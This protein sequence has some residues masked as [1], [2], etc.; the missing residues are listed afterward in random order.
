MGCGRRWGIL[1][2]CR[3]VLRI[4]D[5]EAQA[6]GGRLS[7][8]SVGTVLMV[9]TYPGVGYEVEFTNGDITT[10]TWLTLYD[11]DLEALDETAADR[12]C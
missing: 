2:G 10:L 4:A 11:D 7:G 1:R 9:Y 8:G 3:C 12:S 6:S 5:G